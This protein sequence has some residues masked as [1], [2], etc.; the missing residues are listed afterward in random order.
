MPS[1]SQWNKRVQAPAENRLISQ[2]N[3]QA[4]R[5]SSTL[6]MSNCTQ[7]SEHA[8]FQSA[9]FMLLAS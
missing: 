4:N 5:A 9:G 3:S 2:T 7:A 6:V 8:F 1:G